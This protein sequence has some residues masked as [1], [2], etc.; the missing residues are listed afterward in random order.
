MLRT[1]EL[2][3]I[4]LNE[5][6]L[7]LKKNLEIENKITL[8]TSNNIGLLINIFGLL[9]KNEVINIDELCHYLTN[10]KAV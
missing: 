10:D 6:I 3:K 9:G 2:D 4:T 7:F 5:F 1:Q 8:L